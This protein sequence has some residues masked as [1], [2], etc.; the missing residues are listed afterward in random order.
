ML[1]ATIFEFN[2]DIKNMFELLEAV[3]HDAD[4][5]LDRVDVLTKGTTILLQAAGKTLKKFV[6]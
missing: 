3:K 6:R 2:Q 1:P 5:I 4:E